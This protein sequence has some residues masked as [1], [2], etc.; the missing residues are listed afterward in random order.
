MLS[1]YITLLRG[2]NVGSHH[3]I[4]MA[5][6]KAWLKELG[7]ENISTYIQS[8]NIVFQ[9]N[10]TVTTLLSQNIQK[11]IQD[12]STFTI[13]TLTF[14]K[15]EWDQSIH[16][17]PWK[18]DSSK[19]E[20]FLHFTFLKDE[21]NPEL[22][23][24][25]DPSIF[26]PDEFHIHQKTVYLYCPTSYGKTKLSNSFLEKKLKVEATTRNWKT[27]HELDRMAESISTK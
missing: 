20:L 15:E 11:I 4:K 8:G 7:F 9:T 6:L 24:N 13:P 22:I 1:T 19:K 21:P 2:I 3:I 25:I 26:V 10:E 12:K 5:E 18:N 14:T 17:F 27:V 16:N 23:Q